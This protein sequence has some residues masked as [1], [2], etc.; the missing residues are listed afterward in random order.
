MLNKPIEVFEFPTNLGL[1]RKVDEVEPGV[2]ALPKWL[3]YHG[4]YEALGIDTVYGLPAPF[5]S[6]EYNL[7]TGMLNENQ[8]IE[9]A[10]RQALLL[11][12]HLRTDTFKLLIG[13]DC[14]ILIGAALALK[15]KGSYG[16]F[17]VDGHTD[18]ITPSLSKTG[19]IAGMDLAIAA[20]LGEE[21]ITNIDGLKPYVQ[22][23]HIFCV[24]NREFDRS[25]IAPILDSKIHY[26]DLNRARS[27]G[28]AKIVDAFLKMVEE[29]FLD[30]F[31][32]HLD[33][34]VINDE[35]MPVVDSRA[36]DGFTY[37]E[38]AP[39]LQP[40]LHHSMCIGMEITILDPSLDENGV[41]T[42]RFIDFFLSL[43]EE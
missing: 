31:F 12:K 22:E 41:Y 34:D 39:L 32:I 35:L 8:V 7:K 23:D 25:Y 26:F 28:A 15:K 3:K 1:R 5:Y 29:K 43:L 16:L 19:G 13:G 40:L 27:M 4:F 36:E 18:F 21:A 2:K 33:V 42:K 24:G 30:G 9:F 20:G 11:G 10:E 37:E 38:L 6:M 14:S 17:F